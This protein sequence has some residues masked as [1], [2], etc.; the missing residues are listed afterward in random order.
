MP[1]QLEFIL[2]EKIPK[3]WFRLQLPTPTHY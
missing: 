1:N 2:N 3:N